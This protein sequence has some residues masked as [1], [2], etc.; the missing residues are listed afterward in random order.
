MSK[1]SRDP[2][3]VWP[4]VLQRFEEQALASVM[5]RMALEHAFPAG[6]VDAV[7]EAHR[8]KQY[9]RELLF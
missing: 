1:A 6:W 8:N 3:S 9:A 5:A 2:G 4:A 7:F